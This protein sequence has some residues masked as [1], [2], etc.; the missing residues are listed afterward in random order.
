MSS[1]IR[2]MSR[3]VER[4]IIMVRTQ[5]VLV[6]WLSCAVILFSSSFGMAQEELC[7]DQYLNYEGDF[8]VELFNLKIL[9]IGNATA[10]QFEIKPNLQFEMRL[11][12]IPTG[13][14]TAIARA[15]K[16]VKENFDE[17]SVCLSSAMNGAL[18]DCTEDGEPSIFTWS[19]TRVDEECQVIEATLRYVEFFRDACDENGCAPTVASGVVRRRG[20]EEGSGVEYYYPARGT[21]LKSSTSQ[22]FQLYGCY[23]LLLVLLCL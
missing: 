7:S 1:G 4:A 9:P 15:Y 2:E 8:E 20:S 3:R 13:N 16:G 23:V 14:D 21:V 22:P 18:L 11:T 17:T 12:P 5:Y 6:Y 19:V 10:D